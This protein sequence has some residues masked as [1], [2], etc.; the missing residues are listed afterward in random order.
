MNKT[1]VPGVVWALGL[2]AGLLCS[3][4]S[5][6]DLRTLDDSAL[7]DSFVPPCDRSERVVSLLE[8]VTDKPCSAITPADLAKIKALTVT[9][10]HV[11]AATDEL[12]LGDFSGLTSLRT[13]SLKH[14][15]IETLPPGIFDGLPA[16]EELSLRDNRIEVIDPDVFVNVDTVEFLYLSNNDIE[17]VQS[18]AL[19]G[20][21]SLRYLTLHSNRIGEIEP[22]AFAGLPA[23]EFLGLSGSWF[24]D[25]TF[26]V[27]GLD[28]ASAKSI[29]LSSSSIWFLPETITG[30]DEL[31]TL[32]LNNNHF[33][34]LT[35]GL[36]EELGSLKR[37]ELAR[38]KLATIE[39]GS[40]D[41]LTSLEHLDLRHNQIEALPEGAW[42][43]CASL[44]ELRANDNQ[45]ASLPAML[46]ADGLEELK[47]AEFGDN[48][49]AE[50]AETAFAGPLSIRRIHLGDNLLT[51]LDPQTFDGL[52]LRSLILAN[53]QLASIPAAML[54]DLQ[55]LDF[56]WVGGNGL[57]P[58]DVALIKAELANTEVFGP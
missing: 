19:A 55:E 13:L 43:D 1:A 35:E 58:A 51:E 45:I 20:M 10:V 54:D 12:A 38:G 28:G 6:E 2:L 41:G 11:A 39:P 3:A 32:V 49:I 40:F 36:F 47:F 52:G 14:N 9:Y 17:V 21:S 46:F 16:L 18:G 31:E 34:E 24:D 37:L 50:V 15:G 30:L 26:P 29:D 53:N 57:S 22:G 48:Q 25:H 23:L 56:F 33:I 27:A 44:R 7:A 4:C 5:A 42:A 8:S